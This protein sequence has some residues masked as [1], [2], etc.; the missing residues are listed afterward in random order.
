MQMWGVG[1]HVHSNMH[2]VNCT[3]THCSRCC[4]QGDEMAAEVE[5]FCQQNLV[6]ALGGCCGSRPEHIA[7]IVGM[8]G[9]YPARPKHGVCFFLAT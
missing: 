5:P 4:G 2:E 1:A 7:A 3:A 9:G 8:G 6:N